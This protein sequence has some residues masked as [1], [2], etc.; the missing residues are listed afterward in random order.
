MKRWTDQEEQTAREMYSSGSPIKEISKELGRTI[1]A[2]EYRINQVLD[3]KK[4][5]RWSEEEKKKPE[6]A[7]R[8]KLAKKAKKFRMKK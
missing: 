1:K 3:M 4:M 7:K 2:V 5:P 8:T 6:K